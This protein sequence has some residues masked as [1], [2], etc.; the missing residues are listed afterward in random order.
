VLYEPTAKAFEKYGIKWSRGGRGKLSTRA[1]THY[2]MRRLEKC[3]GAKVIEE[4]VLNGKQVDVLV[5]HD[6]GSVTTVEIAGNAKHEVHNMK[7]CLECR[8]VRR[9]LVVC[10]GSKVL[11]E[12]KKKLKEH[13]DLA[14][15]SRIE[16]V[17]LARAVND[18][19]WTV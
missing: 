12:V 18:E 7:A 10:L 1:A 15:D 2:V 8:E 13:P 9:H 5:R 4:G 19:K 16:M 14:K 11:N 3:A 17:T 6:D